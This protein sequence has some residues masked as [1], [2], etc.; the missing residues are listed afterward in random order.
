MGGSVKN[1]MSDRVTHLIAVSAMGEKYQYAVTFFVP[2][3]TQ[4]WVHTAWAHRDD[5]GAQASEDKL[6]S[7]HFMVINYL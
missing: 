4:Q 3:V 5:L 7:L 1:E 2:V 6:V